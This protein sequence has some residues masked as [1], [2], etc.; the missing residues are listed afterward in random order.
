M[1]M[2]EPQLEATT[3]RYT[4]PL[5]IRH[6]KAIV[7]LCASDILMATVQVVRSGGENNLHSH[8]RLDGFWFVLRGRARFYTEDD[9]LLGE[10]G[11]HEGVFVPRGVPY[12]FESAGDEDL[13]LLQVE[14]T[15]TPG[16]SGGR[17]NH[18]P[19]RASYDDHTQL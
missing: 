19:T 17:T 11:K 16:N 7:K 12:W 2:S 15:S 4:K 1:Q 14:A 9:A 13:E 8:D 10:F 6:S 18:A 5:E 3:I